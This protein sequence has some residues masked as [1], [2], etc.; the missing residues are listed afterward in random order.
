MLVLHPVGQV[1][2][3]IVELVLAEED[4]GEIRLEGW[5]GTDIM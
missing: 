4:L 3:G 1:V 5:L 2:Q